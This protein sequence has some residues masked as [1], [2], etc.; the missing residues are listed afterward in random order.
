LI[1]TLL[2]STEPYLFDQLSEHIDLVPPSHLEILFDKIDPFEEVG[3]F[4][5][6]LYDITEE[7]ILKKWNHF[8]D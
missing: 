6:T 2:D 3:L 1:A 7:T 4:G 8:S 5:E